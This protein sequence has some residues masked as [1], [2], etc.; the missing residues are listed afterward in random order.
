MKFR[1]NNIILMG[2]VLLALFLVAIYLIGDKIGSVWNRLNNDFV[3][4][5]CR[6]RSQ[7]IAYEFKKTEQLQRVVREFFTSKKWQEEEELF[8]SL[9]IIPQLDTK[10][11]RI[12]YFVD[13]EN[14]LNVLDKD[15]TSFYKYKLS[16]RKQ[17]EFREMIDTLQNDRYSGTYND[18]GKI[19][20]TTVDVIRNKKWGDV[21]LGFD[22]SLPD[23]HTYFSEIT[24]IFRSYVFIVNEKGT[25]LSHPDERLL[26]QKLMEKEE[27]D[28]IKQV[29]KEKKELRILA[30]S[31][32]LKVPVVRVYFPLEVGNE[33]WIIG[34]NVPQFVYSEQTEEFHR[35]AIIIALITIL[36]FTVL[37]FLAQHKWR[38][39]Y[40]L[41]RKVER[42]SVE[43]NLQQLKN[44]INPHFL[45][46]SL[47]SLSALIGTD[48]VL[49]KEFVLKL[50]KVYRYLLEKRNVSLATVR[51]ELEF[52]RQYYFLQKIRFGESLE[53]IFDIDSDVFDL[54]IPTMS[55]QTLVENAIKHNQVTVQKPLWIKIYVFDD[56]VVVENNYQPRTESTVESI[57]VGLERIRKMYEFYGRSGFEF[58]STGAYF[59]CKLP[60]LSVDS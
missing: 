39:E 56:C 20:W 24:A 17:S 49:A 6:Y 12:W 47:N 28:S 36:I 18:A 46:N 51:D 57:G 60:L 8:S 21:L 53:L 55:L 32:Y 44:Q 27:L 25:I 59:I 2:F 3:M 10:L 45:F 15:T 50:S 22:I 7:T 5:Q 19:Y 35:Y 31:A 29:L 11:S 33:R 37:L 4:D 26:G 16:E 23:L 38:K 52:T 9:M 41:R 43:L 40:R 54:K 34:V 1:T 48:T 14:I 30:N 58:S 42:E 13:G